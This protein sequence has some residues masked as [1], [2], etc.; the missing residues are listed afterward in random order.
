MYTA[1]RIIAPRPPVLEEERGGGPAEDIVGVAVGL[2]LHTV[3]VH[4]LPHD[5]VQHSYCATAPGTSDASRSTQSAVHTP[6]RRPRVGTGDGIG[7]I[8]GTAVT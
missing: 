7:V 5:C 1:S 2:A 8:G 4:P 6:P 3:S